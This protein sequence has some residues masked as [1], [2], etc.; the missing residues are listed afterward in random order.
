[1][2]T[3]VETCETCKQFICQ[4]VG[5]KE[6][7]I[8]YYLDCTFRMG[9]CLGQWCQEKENIVQRAANEGIKAMK[10][11]LM[12]AIMRIVDEPDEAEEPEKTN[13]DESAHLQNT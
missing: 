2:R 5:T 10:T 7:R 1:M 12:E 3:Q 8:Q 9:A 6:Q 11:V 13:N 4:V